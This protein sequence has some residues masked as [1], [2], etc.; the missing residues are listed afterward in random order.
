MSNDRIQKYERILE[1]REY[2]LNT[3]EMLVCHKGADSPNTLY[4][5]EHFLR[6]RQVA[7]IR[8]YRLVGEGLSNP[9][10][11]QQPT[12]VLLREAPRL[13][14]KGYVIMVE[15]FN[16]QFTNFNGTVKVHEHSSNWSM[17]Y[18]VGRGKTVRMADKYI[19]G[20]FEDLY[21]TK[22]PRA[23]REVID[24][25]ASMFPIRPVYLEWSW[26]VLPQGFNKENAIFWDY[27]KAMG[28]LDI[29]NYYI[30]HGIR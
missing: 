28:D 3:P 10:L 24:I 4:E 11:F 15:S 18:C 27:R 6:R 17:D 5:V 16:P 8:T 20:D 13:V 7:N 26:S 25:A 2:G 23:L 29:A 22:L 19:E 30:K 14:H 21:G 9:H 1:L 12:G